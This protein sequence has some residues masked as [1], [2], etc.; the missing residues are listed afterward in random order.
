MR[1]LWLFVLLQGDRTSLALAA[2]P[3]VEASV[4]ARWRRQVEDSNEAAFRSALRNETL[5]PIP[6]EKA[7]LAEVVLYQSWGPRHSP[8][9]KTVAPPPNKSWPFLTPGVQYSMTEDNGTKHYVAG[10]AEE[11]AVL[12]HFT[13]DG[14]RLYRLIRHPFVSSVRSLRACRANLVCRG[15]TTGRSQP[16]QRLYRV[17]DAKAYRGDRIVRYPVEELKVSYPPPTPKE[18]DR[19]GKVP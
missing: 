19:C 15:T 12:D 14:K 10:S 5:D 1:A 16:E 11:E 6:D 13:S 17:K 9:D 3:C 18:L 7:P 4:I 8:L 2:E